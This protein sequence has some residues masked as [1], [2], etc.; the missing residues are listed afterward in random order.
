K[1]GPLG[2]GASLRAAD[3]GLASAHCTPT[4]GGAPR[5]GCPDGRGCVRPVPG[6]PPAP[7]ALPLRGSAAAVG[8]SGEGLGVGVG[9]TGVARWLCPSGAPPEIHARRRWCCVP[10][11]AIEAPPP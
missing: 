11:G 7:E 3:E 9:A 1:V 5:L 6:L 4:G 8:I 2:F 10:L